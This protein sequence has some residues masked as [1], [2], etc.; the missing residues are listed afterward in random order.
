MRCWG[1]IDVLQF[2]EYGIE[3]KKL[4]NLPKLYVAE[5]IGIGLVFSYAENIYAK[6]F[7]ELLVYSSFLPLYWFG[8]L[9]CI[10]HMRKRRRRK[11]KKAKN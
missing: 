5:K 4:S 1:V 3:G 7:G 9:D 6:M 8:S 2:M 10:L 11:P